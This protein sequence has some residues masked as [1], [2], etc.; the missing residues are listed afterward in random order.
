[1]DRKT[2][3]I[4]GVF[5][6]GRSRERAKELRSTFRLFIDNVQLFTQIKWKTYSDVLTSKCYCIIVLNDSMPISR[7]YAL[8][9]LPFI[10]RDGATHRT[11]N[12]EKALHNSSALS[13][14]LYPTNILIVS[15]V[16][17]SSP[18]QVSLLVYFQ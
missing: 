15:L 2:R 1:M 4:I 10:C 9:S 8:I 16:C 3:E 17:L 13:L 14:L 5:T 12:R 11:I 18:N 7:D 6:G